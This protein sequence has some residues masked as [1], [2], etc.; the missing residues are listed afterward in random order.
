MKYSATLMHICIFKTHTNIHNLCNSS[1][2]LRTSMHLKRSNCLQTLVWRH[3]LVLL[4]KHKGLKSDIST[5]HGDKQSMYSCVP[6]KIHFTPVTKSFHNP[7]IS[8]SLSGSLVHHKVS[9]RIYLRIFQDIKNRCNCTYICESQTNNI[10]S[11]PENSLCLLNE[12]QVWKVSFH[13]SYFS[14]SAFEEY[15]FLWLM[16]DK[17]FEKVLR[18]FLLTKD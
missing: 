9:K 7:N 8:A 17:V 13:D 12:T 11:E 6:L 3:S 16:K 10:Y 4:R 2:F 1:F 14:N 5:E 18:T 15:T